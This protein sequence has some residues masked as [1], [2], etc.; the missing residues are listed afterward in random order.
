MR[1]KQRNNVKVAPKDNAIVRSMM[2]QWGGYSEDD[3]SPNEMLMYE[4]M[5]SRF[6]DPEVEQRKAE[7][8][9]SYIYFGK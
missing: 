3:V 6:Q 8:E 1:S 2:S 4:S 9:S 7:S 5:M